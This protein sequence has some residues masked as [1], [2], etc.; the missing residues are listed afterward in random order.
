[1]KSKLFMNQNHENIKQSSSQWHLR[2]ILLLLYWHISGVEPSL[3]VSDHRNRDISGLRC[4]WLS[5]VKLLACLQECKEGHKTLEANC[6]AQ[7]NTFWAL[8]AMPLA[9]QTS[10]VASKQTI[11]RNDTNWLLTWCVDFFRKI[12]HTCTS[13]QLYWT[14]RPT[15]PRP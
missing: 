4:N 3:Q 6:D 5:V 2:F 9:L 8:L 14:H 12:P 15:V 10:D 1:M 7:V 11:A 13:I